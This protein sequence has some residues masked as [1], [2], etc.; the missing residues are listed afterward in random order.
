MRR[1]T[2][3]LRFQPQATPPAG[4]PPAL[5]VT[6]GPGTVTV[7]D[8][9]D[10]NGTGDGAPTEASYVTH[11]TMTGEETFEE[12]GEIFFDGGSLRVSTAVPGIMRAVEAAGTV[13]GSVIWQVEGTGRF[14]GA[15]GLVTSSF[16]I[17]MDG[18][19]IVEEQVA[20]LLLP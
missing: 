19:G 16:A 1:L 2:L 4:D 11:V 7:L 13:L 18:S 17:Q 20:R 3:L 12:T 6:S 5:D 10:E 8:G 15:T 14:D 9:D